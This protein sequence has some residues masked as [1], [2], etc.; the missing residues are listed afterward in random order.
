MDTP[1]QLQQGATHQ[2]TQVFISVLDVND[3]APEFTRE[4]YTASMKNSTPRGAPLTLSGI[5]EVT[6]G[7]RVRVIFIII[8]YT[9]I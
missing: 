2:T 4:S 1:G 7:D 3:N 6:D 5:I 9:L 8:S